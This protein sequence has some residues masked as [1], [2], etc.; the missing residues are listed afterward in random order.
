MSFRKKIKTASPRQ[1]NAWLLFGTV[2]VIGVAFIFYSFIY[3]KDNEKK[4]VKKRF[5]VLAQIGKNIVDRKKG[6]EIIVYNLRKKIKKNDELDI[7]KGKVEKANKLLKV[8]KNESVK[9]S[10]IVKFDKDS[11]II[12]D[13]Y[14]IYVDANDFFEPLKRTDVFD[15]LIVLGKEDKQKGSGKTERRYVALYHTFPGHIDIFEPEKPK[16]SEYGIESGCLKDIEISNKKYKLFFQPIKL[17]DNKEEKWYVG[18]LV[19][20]KNFE[21]ETRK[22]KSGYITPLLIIFS[23]FILSIP[24]L[25]L[26][27]MSKFEQ[28]NI[29][30]V[31]LTYISIIFGVIA[32]ILL[33]L[34]IFQVSDD[35]NSVKKN[36]KT[37][38]EKVEENFIIEL[39][40]AYEQLKDYDSKLDSKDFE[41][42]PGCDNIKNILTNP[43]FEGKCD[44]QIDSQLKKILEPSVYE[45]SKPLIYEILKPLIYKI[46]K[47][48]IYKKV[49]PSIY[50]L[51]KGVYWMDSTGEQILQFSTRNYGGSL[52]NLEHRKYFQDAGNWR[53]SHGEAGLRFT[54]KWI[55]KK[56]AAISR[57]YE[58]IR[59]L[60]NKEGNLVKAKKAE[61]TTLIISL[62]D[63][64]KTYIC[65]ESDSRFMLESITSITSGEN[66][67]AISMRSESSLKLKDKE[68]KKKS[69]KVAAMTSL[70]TSIIDTIMPAGYGFCII[71]KDGNVLFHSKTE[72]NLQ[73]NFKDE[74]ENDEDLSSAIYSNQ[75]KHLDLDYQNMSHKC[76]VMPVRDIPLYIIT[77]HDMRYT[78]ATQGYVVLYTVFLTLILS[79]FNF[80]HFVIAGW[81]N[82]RKSRLKR[83]FDLFGWLRPLK[84]KKNAY[85]HLIFSTLLIFFFFIVFKI[86][87]FTKGAETLFLCVS[88]NLF[89]FTYNYYTITL[90]ENKRYRLKE[91]GLMFFFLGFLLLIDFIAWSMLIPDKFIRL[92]LFQVSLSLFIGFIVLISYIYRKF[93][94][95]RI[96]NKYIQ[97]FR[98]FFSSRSYIYF[99]LSWLVLVWITPVIMF[100][101]DAYNIENE[102]AVKHLQVKL[103]ERIEDR[104][105]R[106]DRFYN[107]KMDKPNAI[108]T[109]KNSKIDFKT[110][111]CTKLA[112]KNEGIYSKIIRHTSINYKKPNIYSPEIIDNNKFNKIVCFLKP[113][114]NRI[115]AERRDF[116]FPAASDKSRIWQ[117]KNDKIYLQ[118][119]IKNSLYNNNSED[120][121]NLYIVSNMK[122]FKMPTGLSLLLSVIAISIILT[123]AYYLIRLFARRIYGLDL[124]EFE[125]K[126]QAYI[127]AQNDIIDFV[128]TGSNLIIY[129][130]TMKEMEYCDE[131][132]C[133]ESGE[134]AVLE[135]ESTENS[136]DIDM[137]EPIEV[138]LFDVN[139][140]DQKL[141]VEKAAKSKSKKVFIKNLELCSNDIDGN[142]K[143]MTSV[144]NLL[145]MP[146]LQVV[147]TTFKPM[148][149]MIEFYEEK[150][151]EFPTK[152]K[153][154][155]LS[156]S[157]EEMKLKF[158]E[159]ID[160]L[161]EANDCLVP[162]Y[163]PLITIDIITS[164]E[165]IKNNKACLVINEKEDEHIR[166]LILKEFGPAE[167]FI[168][169]KKKIAQ[170]VCRYYEKLKE[171]EE[172]KEEKEPIKEEEIILKIQ[173]LAQHYYSKL[174]DACTSEEKYILYDMARDMLVNTKNEEAIT[175][176]LKKGLLV[177]NG[178]GGFK[179]MN[180]SFRNFILTSIDPDDLRHY[181]RT[182]FPRWKSYKAPLLLIALGLAVILA[183][184]ENLLSNV[185]A[186]VTTAI[187]GIAIITRFS[188]L[189]LN[190]PKSRSK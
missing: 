20:N 15:E 105:F 100:Y 16:K 30:D 6:F 178:E 140:D 141:E 180:E 162:F 88:V 134:E 27:L 19:D 44:T 188:G 78:S 29:N 116:I 145:R 139:S 94:K 26:L 117:K 37:L 43:E 151:T 130:Q 186:L 32:L 157:A 154:A 179:L 7:I 96:V 176:L 121:N 73:E 8:D 55:G 102:V 59:N 184:Q 177:Y 35:S 129:C 36:L 115:A 107:E 164:K 91:Y 49:K 132:F 75:A 127:E 66:L 1:L 48:P 147:I 90:D 74:V 112:R 11:K 23:I 103:A 14:V 104:N 99:L 161:N 34:F 109:G 108:S 87:I 53:L 51:F 39:K 10:S 181:G 47:P 92:I 182:L 63:L 101:I 5:R 52:V 42:K 65:E 89:V 22:F 72:R 33:Y 170:S 69:L 168:D 62:V 31:V 18:G 122:Y 120:K 82:Y 189:F 166:E 76:F 152:E 146:T 17:D 190:F 95:P 85:K 54:M 83:K 67:A 45:I 175:I 128:K 185:D 86:F 174:L 156:T 111:R 143:K 173:E 187:G 119:K 9:G 80:L 79:L 133:E 124:P 61:M 137:N 110:I 165:K 167:F 21:K 148:T 77:F 28:L 50:E 2:L 12:V 106:I 81:S 58:S 172:L 60:K 149:E 24:L 144:I 13:N 163:T 160:L 123:L 135:D 71:D 171:L 4:Q 40:E 183:F 126:K 3:V 118:Y 64:I 93:I 131:L 155:K 158:K 38:A 97:V 159:M 46:L 125:N 41:L 138:Y 150:L 70:F 136:N 114:M 57:I 84:E 169:E 25:K 113:P 142:R 98:N 68:G 153:E 56:L